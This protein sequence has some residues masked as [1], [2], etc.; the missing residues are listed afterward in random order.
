MIIFRDVV[1]DFELFSDA[2]RPKP[3][4]DETDCFTWTSKKITEKSDIDASKLGA[5]A[6]AEE[7]AE[8]TEESSKT[9]FDFEIFNPE[10]EQCN[11]MS[12]KEFKLWFKVYAKKVLA[13]L[14]EKGKDEQ[15]DK[16][17][18]SAQKFFEKFTGDKEK[19]KNFDFYS[20]PMQDDD[21]EGM[22]YGNL[23]ILDWNDDGVSATCYCWRGGLYEE[24]C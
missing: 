19:F 2:L 22:I 24:K 15:A 9:A 17:K 13:A 11:A 8:E 18:A 6:S 10:I 4:D 1:Y 7:A 21:K 12:M 14:K 3:V 5:N 20:G 16:A 23:I